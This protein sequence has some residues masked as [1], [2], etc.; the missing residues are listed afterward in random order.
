MGLAGGANA[1]IG[2]DFIGDVSKELRPNKFAVVAEI[3]E[4]W[5]TPM[6]TRME[7]IDGI[8]FR[9]AL[10]DVTDTV[11]EEEVAAMK[12]DISQPKMDRARPCSRRPE[13]KAKG[14]R[15]EG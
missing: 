13:S 3:R 1:G 15:F 7:A 5:T 12:A 10:S 14:R 11:D 2:A 8:V 6:D 4:C 9:W